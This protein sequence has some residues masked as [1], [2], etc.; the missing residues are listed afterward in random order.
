MTLE[1]ISRA[2][3]STI[4]VHHNVS[5]RCN[6]EEKKD[7]HRGDLEEQ[8][9]DSCNTVSEAKRISFGDRYDQ[10]RDYLWPIL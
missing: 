9:G 7:T 1:G 3:R 2:E 8:G 6:A 4:P 5:D 10:I